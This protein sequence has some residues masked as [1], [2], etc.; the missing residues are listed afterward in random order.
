MWVMGD[1]GLCVLWLEVSKI[2]THVH[3]EFWRSVK[4]V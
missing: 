4:W 3:G 1:G 2:N